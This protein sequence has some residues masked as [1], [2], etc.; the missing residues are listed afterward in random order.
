ML[1]HIRRKTTC[2]AAIRW[3]RW[4]MRN[5]GLTALFANRPSDA[6]PPSGYDLWC[7]YRTVRRRF[8]ASAVEYGAGCSTLVIAE[9]LHRNGVGHLVSF[10]ANPR[11]A[12]QIERDIPPY[13]RS[14][15][16]LVHSPIEVIEIDGERCHRFRDPLPHGAPDFVYLDGPHPLDIPGWAG[17]ELAADPVIIEEKLAPHSQIMV[18]ARLA[19]VAFLKRHLKRNYRVW[20]HDIFKVTVFS[21]K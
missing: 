14:R 11:W 10:E 15:I 17:P 5:S 4:R 3:A 18:D 6:I 9:A 7:L 2:N 8:T 13:L 1:E 12:A 21:L 16:T 19:N 20:H